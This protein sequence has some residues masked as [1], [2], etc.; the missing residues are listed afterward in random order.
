MLYLQFASSIS[1]LFCS[2]PSR[3]MGLQLFHYTGK[4]YF[5]G[6]KINKK[7]LAQMQDKSSCHAL[8]AQL[9]FMIYTA[10]TKV[11][12]GSLDQML[13]VKSRKNTCRRPKKASW[14]PRSG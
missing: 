14:D 5:D 12:P 9:E 11:G 7:A 6:I 2:N 8:S 1:F 3:F 13:A 4:L 10:G